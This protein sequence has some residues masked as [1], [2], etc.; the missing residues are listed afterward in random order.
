MVDQAQVNGAAKVE[1][2]P[3]A[4][5]RN[6]GELLQDLVTLAELQARLLVLDVR[7]GAQRLL[8]PVGL[9]LVGTAIAVACLP[10]AFITVALALVETTKLTLAQAF[11]V[12]LLSGMV[13]T[14]LIAGLGWALFRRRPDLLERSRAEWQQNVKWTKH[15]LRRLGKITSRPTGDKDNSS[16]RSPW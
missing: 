4:V 7:D 12:S 14:T 13:L 15:A 2:A 10:V 1:A 16:A 8:W 11:G 5:A 6:T 9:L 3:R